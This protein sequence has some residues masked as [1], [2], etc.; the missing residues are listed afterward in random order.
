[1]SNEAQE[2]DALLKGF[3][4]EP[5]LQSEMAEAY[6]ARQSSRTSF[7]AG[8]LDRS[9]VLLERALE[10][11]DRITGLFLEQGRS[12]WDGMFVEFGGIVRYELALVKWEIS[13][14]NYDEVVDLLQQACGLFQVSQASEGEA[15]AWSALADLFAGAGDV[16]AAQS[17]MKSAI[18][19][20]GGRAS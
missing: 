12:N 13:E 20:G 10:I 18:D 8:E 1:M 19:A 3:A 5:Q 4:S 14:D 9:R 17:A 15:R 11:T 16:T 6:E 2:R 7:E